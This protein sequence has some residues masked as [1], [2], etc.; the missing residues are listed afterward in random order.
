MTG[1]PSSVTA[2]S[3]AAIKSRNWVQKNS[4][5]PLS[6][7]KPGTYRVVLDSD[8]DRYVGEAATHPATGALGDKL[9]SADLT[10]QTD[11]C[12]SGGS[13]GKP[14]K[15]AIPYIGEHAA[16]VLQWQH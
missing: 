2:V 4:R 6:A 14:C 1:R 3:T 13:H 10:I 11:D 15:L 9:R 12:R 16:I 5:F 8:D 7:L